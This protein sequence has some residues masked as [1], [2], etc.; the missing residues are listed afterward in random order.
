MVVNMGKVLS[1]DWQYVS[2][3]SPWWTSR[4]RRALVKVILRTV[5]AGKS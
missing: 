4:T 5:F 2:E 1:G 3:H